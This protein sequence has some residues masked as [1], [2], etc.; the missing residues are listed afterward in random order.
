MQIIYVEVVHSWSVLRTGS[1][2]LGWRKHAP[3][4]PNHHCW[5]RRVS[6]YVT[7]YAYIFP[8]SLHFLLLHNRHQHNFAYRYSKTAKI[9]AW[10]SSLIRQ[11]H[12]VHQ[13]KKRGWG[14]GREATNLMVIMRHG[15]HFTYKRTCM[16]LL[17]ATCY[18]ST[19]QY[20]Y[21]RSYH[22]VFRGNQSSLLHPFEVICSTTVLSV[23]TN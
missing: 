8:A 20:M 7:R 5:C 19:F 21:I 12:S 2:L 16:S 22:C 9:A 17:H 4:S 14:D 18:M 13:E 23:D 1:L 6:C 11:L 3:C 15:D 10:Y